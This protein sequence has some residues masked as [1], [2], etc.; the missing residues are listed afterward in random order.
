M[1]VSTSNATASLS[2]TGVE[3]SFNPGFRAFARTDVSVT[4]I[5]AL[6]VSTPLTLDT[7]FSV[8]LDGSGNVTVTPI[9]LPAAPGTLVINRN[10]TYLQATNYPDGVSIP[11]SSHQNAA[12]IAAMR[13]Q[14]MR[15]DIDAAR[16]ILNQIVAGDF[17]TWISI[18][19]TTLPATPG[20]IWVNGG[21]LCV[22]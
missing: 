1:T 9:A 11:S 15:R 21:V 3:T 10:S 6:L 14:E 22:S 18:L 16:A 2:W 19:P 5:N 17:A 12:D 8:T 13:D 20:K 7:H 4:F